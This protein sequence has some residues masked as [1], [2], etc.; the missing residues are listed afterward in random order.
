MHATGRG[1]E[2]K[3]QVMELFFFT[4]KQLSDG[5][6]SPPGHLIACRLLAIWRFAFNLIC[7]PV[8]KNQGA[9]Q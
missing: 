5:A 4:N 6:D 8:Q 3:K 9:L 7:R 2:E 1:S